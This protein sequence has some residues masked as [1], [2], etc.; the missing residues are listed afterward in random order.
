MLDDPISRIEAALE[1]GPTPSQWEV[2]DDSR[3]IYSNDLVNDGEEEWRPLIAATC[4]D[5]TLIDFEA[6]ARYIAACN[7]LAI[8][9]LLDRLKAAEAENERLREALRPAMDALLASVDVVEHEYVTDWRHGMPTRKAQLDA[10]AQDLAEHKQAID[11]LAA[12][13]EDTDAR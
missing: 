11:L 7:P 4:D 13:L 10:K 8:R 5:E 1:A 12:A 3:H 6:N 9:A 2:L